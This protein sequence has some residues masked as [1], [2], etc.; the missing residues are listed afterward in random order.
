MC[1][2][3]F[4]LT[5]SVHAQDPKVENYNIRWTTPSTNSQG[6]MPI[7]NGDIGANV[8]VEEN[9]DLVFYIS[10]TDAWSE[11]GR[12]LKLGKVRI[13]I[14]PSPILSQGFLQELKLKNG[15]ISIHMSTTN[16]RFWIDANHP[17]I[18]T[19]ITS[20][21]PV[22]V[23]VSYEN[24]RKEKRPILGDEG[25]S[26]WGLGPNQRSRNCRADIFQEPDKIIKGNHNKI[27]SFHHNN[28][29][30]YEEGLQVQA[31]TD[32]KTKM[33]D[34]LLHRNYGVL[35]AGKGLKN[36]SDTLLAS[37]KAANSF[38][39]QVFP[40]TQQGTEDSWMHEAE[41]QA[42]TL[43]ATNTEVRFAAHKQ[44]WKNFWNRSYI[45]L[46]SD[47]AAEN[48]QAQIVTQGYIL[49]RFVNACSGRG[50]S[51]IKFNG[52][53]FTTDTYN[54]K[55]QYPGYDADFRNWGGCYWWQNT[56]LPYWG[57][58]ASGD[59]D[60][61]QP[62]FKMYMQALPL[63][64]TATRKYYK[65]DG[66]FF[67]ETMNFWGTYADSD[68]GCKRD[69]V[70]D[71][72]TS[73]PYITYYWQSGLELSLM[74]ADYYSFTRSTTFAKD[75][76]LPFVSNILKF[77][78]RHWKRGS[79][80]K[81]RFDPSHSLETYHKAV[82]PL[83]EIVG[84]RKVVEKMIALPEQFT[85]SNKR[86]E[87]KKLIADLPS[88]PMRTVEGK[89]L[90]APAH[91]YSSK[92]NVENPEMYAVFP[93]R[94]YA[95]GKPDLDLAK[96]TFASKVH[97]ENG[98]WQQNSIQSAYLGLAEESKNMIVQS[99]STHDNNFRFPAFWGPNYDWTPD[100]CHGNVAM[101]A[102][103]RML[104]QYEDDSTTMLPAWPKEWNVR[105][106][107]NMPN[108]KTYEGMYKDGKLTKMN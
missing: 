7:G 13:A 9:G 5:Q 25:K 60:L 67:P 21:T 12:L 43:Q 38:Q 22:H 94:T 65:H 47:D 46:S 90:L 50:N 76:L 44:W 42:R 102:L 45:F 29:S 3:S 59:F 54:R 18:Q 64:I 100:Q 103:Q 30:I 97:F 34:P 78:D 72:T 1:C 92:A 99:F 8:W 101:I 58:I 81:I 80:G 37:T 10:K 73:N 51:A 62:L 75:T 57:M 85:N 55:G 104:M 41:G 93:Y 69:N 48:K 35:I 19:D 96:R 53:I 98:G 36:L 52:S 14:S 86:N 33:T 26:V 2:A 40:L 89:T 74:M 108:K 105:F 82:D 63:R 20:K 56:R 77:Y 91:E 39:I 88:V 11:I 28:Y 27:V 15:E 17:V 6:S 4:V 49:Q 68:Y 66:A 87:W 83:P 95:I 31:L 106:K 84:I 71:G 16:I 32:F 24:W 61:M 107:L 70:P 79:D 23:K